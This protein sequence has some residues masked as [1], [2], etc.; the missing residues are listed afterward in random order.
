MNNLEKP[1]VSKAQNDTKED[2]SSKKGSKQ[3]EKLE[4]YIEDK[5]KALEMAKAENPHRVAAIK[6]REMGYKELAKQEEK[7]AEKVGEDTLDEIKER[8]KKEDAI[9]QS[10][11]SK[12]YDAMETPK[13]TRTDIEI[14]RRKFSNGLL[15]K[16]VEF[17]GIERNNRQWTETDLN[18]NIFYRWTGT[19]PE[20]IV[21]S[22]KK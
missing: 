5:D 3:D 2:K 18:E 9:F 17:L 11:M 13:D 19:W 21:T 4:T 14:P 22:R 8:K 16:L 20:F 1:D 12:M 7:R 15:E 6:A 10:F